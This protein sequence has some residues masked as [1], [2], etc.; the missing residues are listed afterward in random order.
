M[1]GIESTVK[2]YLLDEFLPGAN[3]GELTETTPLIS[4][5]ILDS[6]ATLKLLAFLE[7]QFGIEVQAHEASLNTIGLIGALV[8]SKR[9]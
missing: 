9:A 8:R 3:P 4:G 7:E 6:L 1:Q 5:G 2:Q